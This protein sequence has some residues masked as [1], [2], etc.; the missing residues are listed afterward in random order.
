[1]IDLDATPPPPLPGM[2]SVVL[3]FRCPADLAAWV[4][5]RAARDHTSPGTTLRR[6]VARERNNGDRWPTDVNRW[7]TAQAACNSTPGDHDAAIIALVRHLA[8]RWPN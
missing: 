1:M 5:E 4:R 7:L 6:I 3:A 2:R 8:T